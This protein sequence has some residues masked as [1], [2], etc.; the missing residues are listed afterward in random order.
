M[1]KSAR[2]GALKIE[3][4]LCEMEITLRNGKIEQHR[5]SGLLECAG[6]NKPAR[7]PNHTYKA[8]YECA[9]CSQTTKSNLLTG[10]V[11]S[12]NLPDST[13][14][15]SNSS[16]FIGPV[17]ASVTAVLVDEQTSSKKPRRGVNI[18]NYPEETGNSIRTVSGG[19]PGLGRRG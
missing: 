10:V 13:E 14:V 12:H 16:R 8:D 5:T 3:C 9:L 2:N 6:S 18:R 15:C 19:S 7:V 4:P 17:G 11:Y 1:T